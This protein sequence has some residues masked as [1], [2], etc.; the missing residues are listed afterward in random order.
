MAKTD[1]IFNNKNYSVDDSFIST[2]SADLK[3]HF[4]NVMNG[5]GAVINLGGAAYNVDSAKLA[6]AKNAFIQH[7]GTIAGSGHKVVIGGVEYGIDAGKVAGA[8]SEIEAVLGG[9]ISGGESGGSGV[10]YAAT[11]ADN[12]WATIAHAC[13]N[14]AV[15][16]TWV[17]GDVKTMMIGEN[18][19]EIMIIGKNHDI[20]A[21]GSGTAPLTFMTKQIIGLAKINTE[22]TNASGW[23]GSEMYTYL[24][25]DVFAM[26]DADVQAVI[27]PVVKTTTKG[28]KSYETET[29]NDK[30]FLLSQAEAFATT[31][32]PYN[33]EGTQYNYFA[34]GDSRALCEIV[35]YPQLWWLRSPLV[36]NRKKF[37]FVYTDGHLGDGYATSSLGVAFAFCF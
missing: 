37:R 23:N 8:V 28:D 18:E 21:D 2:H 1:I 15:P 16:D 19:V 20:Y 22:A 30:L 26:L 3:S 10:T 36:T 35:G 24:N 32:N 14:N 6:T 11:F 34:N 7:L 27:K 5:T 13:Q 25:T 17:V 9:S 29:S 33:M 12:D 4:S 31:D